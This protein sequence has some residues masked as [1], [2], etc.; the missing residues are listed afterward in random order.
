MG[1]CTYKIILLKRTT[2]VV[3]Q[4]L[5]Y[6]VMPSSEAS[7]ESSRNYGQL[8]KMWAVEEGLCPH[9]GHEEETLT[10]HLWRFIDCNHCSIYQC[11]SYIGSE[12]FGSSHAHVH[13]ICGIIDLQYL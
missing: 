4:I 7:S 11:N 6:R 2:D 13:Y 10:H 12:E 3:D 9:K 1:V 8:T 5:Q